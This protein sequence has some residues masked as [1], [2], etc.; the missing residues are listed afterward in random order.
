MTNARRFTARLRLALRQFQTHFTYAHPIDSKHCLEMTPA[1]KHD[2]N[3]Y[4]NNSEV[5]GTIPSQP[6]RLTTGAVVVSVI[7]GPFVGFIIAVTIVFW[8]RL[9][10]HREVVPDEMTIILATLLGTN[11]FLGLV[12]G[13]F[14]AWLQASLSL[15]MRNGAVFIA[16]LIA[17]ASSLFMFLLLH[18]FYGSP[19]IDSRYLLGS[20]QLLSCFIHVVVA[21]FLRERHLKDKAVADG[22]V[23][24]KQ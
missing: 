24:R 1:L 11:L 12:L 22:D 8:M 17:T 14:A 6:K 13:F 23:A 9:L 5:D 18:Y 10:Q 16:A 20:L 7:S 3:P 15:S 2:T 21:A 19:Q 4:A